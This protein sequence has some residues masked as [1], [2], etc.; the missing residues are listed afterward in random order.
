MRKRIKFLTWLLDVDYEKN[1]SM[2]ENYSFPDISISIIENHIKRDGREDD[3]TVKVKEKKYAKILRDAASHGEFYPNDQRN[4]FAHMNFDIHNEELLSESSIVRIENSKGIPRIGINLQYGILHK[5]VMDNLSDNTKLKY[6]F[7]VKII[8]AN[9][10]Q[11]VIENS[12]SKDFQQMIILMLNNIIQY[13]IEH[14]FKETESEIDNLDLAGFSIYDENNNG[15]DITAN[16]TNKDK[17]MNIKNAIGH[18]NITWNE[19]ELILINDWTPS[20]PNRDTRAPIK[21]KI[22]CNRQQL[23]EFLLQS[24]LYNFAISNQVDNSIM[25]RSFK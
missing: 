14:H 20:N 15:I 2:Y 8:E 6:D 13:N 21:R 12:S 22:V 17:L 23:I 9:S 11:D 10:Y 24:D 3:F 5:F 4:N 16:L 19:D 7:L 18:D 25:N 1:V